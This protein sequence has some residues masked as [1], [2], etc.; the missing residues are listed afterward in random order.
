MYKFIIYCLIDCI[1]LMIG[2]DRGFKMGVERGEEEL[3]EFWGH[4]Y[5]IDERGCFKCVKGEK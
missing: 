3:R 5:N 4:Y 1:F 2:L